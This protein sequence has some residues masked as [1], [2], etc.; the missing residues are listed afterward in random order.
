MKKGACNYIL[1]CSLILLILLIFIGCSGQENIYY[2]DKVAALMYHHIDEVESSVTITPQ[3]FA[4]HLEMLE[5]RGYNV[6]SIDDLREFLEGRKSVPPNAVVLTFDDGY[7]SFY[8]YAFP[9][10]KEKDMSAV[11]FMIVRHIGVKKG[12][13][14]KLDWAQ[15][16]EM[17]AHGMSF[18]SH[19][20]DSHVYLKINAH[21]EEQPALVSRAYL[22]AE[23]RTEAQEE[24][25]E[26]IY[27][28]LEKS[29]REL[30]DGLKT[31]VDFFSVPYGAKNA[32]V[33]KVC[34]DIG[35]NYIFTIKPGLISSKTD[36][37]SLPRINA[38]SPD[39]DAEKL[40]QLIDKAK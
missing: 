36:P 38:G 20:Y 27:T 12:Q 34:L 30:E 40:H 24:Y 33:E 15:M 29:K 2:K 14:P 23:N 39:I 11:V 22:A 16:Q 9:I 19:T 7:E 28:D 18:H 8:D 6:I 4:Q 5:Q 17:L 25:I 10:L 31:R 21:G 26:R 13:I 1:L 35:M 37:M 32:E 3:R